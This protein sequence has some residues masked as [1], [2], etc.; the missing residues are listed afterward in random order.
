[1]FDFDVRFL[2]WQKTIQSQRTLWSSINQTKM[3]CPLTL[4]TV[5]LMTTKY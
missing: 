2:S 4:R 1:M 5:S 3:K